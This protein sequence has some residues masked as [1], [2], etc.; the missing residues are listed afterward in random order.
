MVLPHS[1]GEERSE[2]K[3]KGN[4]ATDLTGEMRLAS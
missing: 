3:T 1:L 2:N 4:T